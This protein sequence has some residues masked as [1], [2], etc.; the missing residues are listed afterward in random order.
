ML[1]SISKTLLLIHF[2]GADK[3]PEARWNYDR[4]LFVIKPQKNHAEIQLHRTVGR[5]CGSCPGEACFL[6]ET[7]TF[8][9]TIWTKSCISS[10]L[11]DMSHHL[12]CVVSVLAA[13]FVSVWNFSINVGAVTFVMYV[14]NLA[15]C[16]DQGGPLCFQLHPTVDICLCLSISVSL[17]LPLYLCLCFSIPVS[18]SL[19]LDVCLSISLSLSL[20][21]CL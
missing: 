20:Y 6:L 15:R 7:Q 21:V 9:F 1:L 5:G 14:I 19:S 18:L 8:R 10:A 4:N 11:I 17:C 3:L 13:M 2:C 16:D 12:W